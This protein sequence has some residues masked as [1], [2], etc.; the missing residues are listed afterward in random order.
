MDK[1]SESKLG[2]AYEPIANIGSQVIN[3]TNHVILCKVTPVAPGAASKF[4]MVQVAET[5]DGKC[6]I[7]EVTDLVI[8][9]T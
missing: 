2:A 9:A 3:G 5:I 1:A 8:S 7:T 6:T 4:A